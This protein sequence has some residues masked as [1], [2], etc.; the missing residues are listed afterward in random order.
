MDECDF[1]RFMRIFAYERSIR[2]FAVLR[3]STPSGIASIK[4][5]KAL[6]VFSSI[7]ETCKKHQVPMKD[8]LEFL[9]RHA[10][11]N[12]AVLDNPDTPEERKKEILLA[13]M[14][15]NYNKLN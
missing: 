10:G 11:L 13:G 7:Y 2:D 4:G 5:A 3:H 6:A 12:K 8:Y 14:P 1:Q 9:F 15:W